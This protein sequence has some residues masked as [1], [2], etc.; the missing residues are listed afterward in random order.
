[1][2]IILGGLLENSMIHNHDKKYNPDRNSTSHPYYIS[3]NRKT[4][5]EVKSRCD[6]FLSISRRITMPNVD[7]NIPYESKQPLDFIDTYDLENQNDLSLA[8][9]MLISNRA[10]RPSTYK[11]ISD[12]DISTANKNNP[13]A[14]IRKQSAIGYVERVLGQIEISQNAESILILTETEIKVLREISEFVMKNKLPMPI[15]IPDMT[16]KGFINAEAIG[17][18]S[19]F[20]ADD[21]DQISLIRRDKTINEY[22]VEFWKA[23]KNTNIDNTE[24]DLLLALRT[25]HDNNK[26]VGR[27]KTGFEIFSWVTKPLSYNPITSVGITITND[28]LAIFAKWVNR[29]SKHTSWYLLGVKLEEIRIEEYLNRKNNLL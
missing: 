29:K 8:A 7:W 9:K 24:R 28:V 12:V 23:L 10:L 1:M 3:L 18:L 17:I 27:F 21:I 15:D 4:S 5:D 2:N 26:V 22:A 11:T 13:A 14:Y 16:S 25:A 6:T 19:K 20:S